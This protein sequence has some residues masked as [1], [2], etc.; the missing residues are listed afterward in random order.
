MGFKK[1]NSFTLNFGPQHPAAHGV[2]RLILK[3]EGEI[4]VQA[5]PHIGLLHRGTEKLIEY[6]TYHQALPYLDR[7]DY[8]SVMNSEHCYSLA[9]ES[10]MGLRIPLEDQL[11]RV[12]FSEVTRI[13]NHLLAISTHALDVGAMTPFLWAFDEREKLMIVYEK[14]IGARLHAA[15]IIPGGVT[16]LPT[17]E[18]MAMLWEFCEHF[19]ERLKEIHILLSD[20]P[21]WRDR[22]IDVGIITQ[23]EAL[24]Y[25]FTGP[26]LRSTGASWDLRVA[27]PYDLYH[28]LLG[29]EVFYSE[30][31]DCYDR[32]LLRMY[33]M[34]ESTRLI[35]LCIHLCFQK[36]QWSN[37]FNLLDQHTGSAL[38]PL[39]QPLRSTLSGRSR[40]DFKNH[41][42]TLISQ[43]KWFTEGYSVP[44]NEVYQAVEA[45]KGE[46]GVFLSSNN[47]SKPYRCKFRA[48]GFFHLQGLNIMSKG[49]LLA[50]VVTIIGTQD[51]VFGEI[52]R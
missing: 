20:N 7:L 51:I 14:T 49:H 37:T 9:V 10:L 22:L 52:D 25:G 5:E 26:L 4:I 30:N 19:P 44:T 48:P 43:F 16:S 34:A 11:T 36:D 45:P 47:T 18:T 38:F 39:D 31:G 28:T 12:L 24:D 41:M 42:E 35:Q 33:E 2:L 6:K 15:Y 23:K 13:L 1:L 32:Y 17:V 3:L 46:F 50:D 8:V 21:I 40:I 27:Q 29:I